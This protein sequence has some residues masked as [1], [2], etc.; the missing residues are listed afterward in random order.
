MRGGLATHRSTGTERKSR[1]SWVEAPIGA[2]AHEWRAPVWA[3]RC[4]A[5]PASAARPSRSPDRLAEGRSQGNARYVPG[6]MD[7]FDLLVIPLSYL[8]DRAEVYER[9]PAAAVVVHDWIWRKRGVS[10]VVALLLLK[11]V[12]LVRRTVRCSR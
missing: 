8:G 4:C 11:R 6:R 7:R 5:Q 2:S 9:P 12:N 3:P 10:R 1:R